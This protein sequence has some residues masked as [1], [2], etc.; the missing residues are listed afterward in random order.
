MNYHDAQDLEQARAEM[1]F[2]D[3][4]EGAQPPYSNTGVRFSPP[5][6]NDSQE[7][8]VLCSFD[9]YQATIPA[10]AQAIQDAFT[11]RFGGS[12][13]PVRALN[14]YEHGA[15]HTA[16]KVSVF[17]GGHNPHPNAKGTG[18]DSQMFADFVRAVFPSHRVSRADV[19]FDFDK[20]G[21]FDIIRALVEPLAR[22]AGVSCIFQGD[23]AEND[24]AF[25]GKRKGRTLYMGSR[26]SEVR[27]RLYEKGFE[28]HGKGNAAASA[29]WVRFE[30]VCAPQKARKAQ[31]A[32]LSPFEMVGFSKWISG[33]IG[34]VLE[35]V[36]T[37]LPNADKRIKPVNEVFEHMLHQYGR[38][39]RAYIEEHGWA[40]FDMLVYMSIYSPKERA[41]ME[42]RAVHPINRPGLTSPRLPA[43]T[44]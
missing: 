28:Q 41:K 38:H 19:A 3:S 26:S 40:E 5:L 11:S 20:E 7:P 22:K 15:Q 6:Q 24:P 25:T 2:L 14:G 43:A 44:H 42:Q 9:W 16:Y 37:V 39:L 8:S 27:V 12:F 13:E 29:N 34:T 18:E 17:W 23:D 10:S 1:L 32:T 21:G 36:P 33:A 31:A 35:D 4:L 30:V